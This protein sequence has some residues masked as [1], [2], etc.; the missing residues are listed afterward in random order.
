[1]DTSV[2]AINEVPDGICNRI[3]SQP[4]LL[5]NLVVMNS[6][7]GVQVILAANVR[8]CQSTPET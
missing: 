3:A 8:R 4:S 5:A 1:M 7:A 6:S 2:M